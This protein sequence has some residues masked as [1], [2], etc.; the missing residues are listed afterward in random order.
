MAEE[1]R[2]IPPK[3]ISSIGEAVGFEPISEIEERRRVLV[4]SRKQNTSIYDDPTRIAVLV[5]LDTQVRFDTLSQIPE[6]NALLEFL[7]QP[8]KQSEQIASLIKKIRAEFFKDP[9]FN[10]RAVRFLTTPKE[11]DEYRKNRLRQHDESVQR[12]KRVIAGVEDGIPYANFNKELS[13]PEYPVHPQYVINKLYHWVPNEIVEKIMEEGL[14]PGFLSNAPSYGRPV[15]HASF[16]RSEYWR[17]TMAQARKKGGGVD[18][19]TDPSSYTELEIDYDPTI[20]AYMWPPY[21]SKSPGQALMI[22]SL[23]TVE[24]LGLSP[25]LSTKAVPLNAQVSI[26]LD[27]DRK[28]AEEMEINGRNPGKKWIYSPILH[29]DVP[30]WASSLPQN[31]STSEVLLDYIP[32]SRIHVK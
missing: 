29:R 24:H 27:F 17:E 10:D 3:Q 26:L 1:T 6:Y 14:L 25:L 9:L 30:D 32:P 4:N 18:M 19:H 11:F 21:L 22:N 12:H 2:N 28:E 31:Y 8:N 7:K 16:Q 5:S 13:F 20:E 15:A 23:H